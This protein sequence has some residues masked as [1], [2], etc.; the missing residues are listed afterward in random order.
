MTMA[1]TL[2]TAEI[3]DPST[4]T[5]SAAAAMSM[6]RVNHTATLLSSGQVRGYGYNYGEIFA[7]AEI[8]DPSTNTCSAAASMASGIV[9]EVAFIVLGLLMG[10]V[11]LTVFRDP[12]VRDDLPA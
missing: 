11:R 2:K 5:W 8:Y 7:S 10:I 6:A 1:I 12:R 4:S 3:Y 9:P